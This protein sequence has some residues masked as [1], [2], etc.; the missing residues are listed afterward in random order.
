VGAIHG[1]KAN[2]VIP[3]EV[4]LELSVRSLSP[5]TRKMLEQRLREVIDLQAKSYGVR[6]EI[7]YRYG[8]PVLVNHDEPTAFATAVAT[9]LV[10]E[11]R[12]DPQGKPLSGS[13]DFAYM[14][15]RVPGSFLLVGNGAGEG[16][17]M[18]HN[19]AYDFNDNILQTGASLLVRLTEAFLPAQ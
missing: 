19:P 18:V 3:D 10:G 15:E 8:Y 11:S 12:V 16:A 2:N 1:G 7:D 4:K 9:S 14:L 6:A 17:C 13:E 5:S